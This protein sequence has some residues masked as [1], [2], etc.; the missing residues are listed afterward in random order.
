MRSVSS[1]LAGT[2]ATVAVVFSGGCDSSDAGSNAGQATGSGSDAGSGSSA[3]GAMSTSCPSP[4]PVF[5][6]VDPISGEMCH[7]SACTPGFCSR[8]DIAPL[9]NHDVTQPLQDR[10]V[11]MD[12]SPHSVAPVQIFKEAD[13]ASQLFAYF[14]LDSTGFQPSVFTTIIPGVNDTA[15]RTVWGANCDLPTI[16]SVRLALE[17]KPGLPTDPDDPHAFIDIFTDIRSLFVINNESGWYEG[18]MIHDLKVAPVAPLGANGKSPVGTITPEDA[19]ALLAIGPNNVPGNLFTVDGQAPHLPSPSDHFPDKVT[20]VVSL[21]LSMGAYNALQQSDAHNYWEFNYQTNWIHPLY[22]LPFT[23]GFPSHSPTAPATAYQD[24]LIS[25]R[26][27]IVPGDSPG[28]NNRSKEL[29]VMFGDNPDLPRDPDKFDAEID[30]QREFR[31]R[32]VPSGIAREVFLNTFERL[33]SFEPN[34]H[35]LTQRL[36]KGYKAAIALADTNGNGIIS[37]EEGDI[38]T[39]N[40]NC[41]SGDNSCLFLIPRDYQRFAVTREINDAL[42]APRFAPSTRGFALSGTMVTGF[43]Q[44]SASEGRD[45]DDR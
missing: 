2:V 12:C 22:E 44:F 38:D 14:L 4:V 40:P 36:L 34:E 45:T 31:E 41:P 26:Q 8:S 42:L 24:G 29:A 15:M 16:G 11:T 13:V 5:N 43:P 32:F 23:G 39:P 33:A 28:D 6:A 30:A 21:Y 20:N 19:Q 25:F 7:P 27:S 3:P 9:G 17:P 35:D 1:A 37:A 10:L 18:W